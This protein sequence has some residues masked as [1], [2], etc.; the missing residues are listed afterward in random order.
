MLRAITLSLCLIAA[1][2]QFAK[3]DVY[4][5]DINSIPT[6]PD[7]GGEYTAGATGTGGEETI[8][9]YQTPIYVLS[10][11]GL[12]A[13]SEVNLGT[14]VLSSLYVSDQYR[15]DGYEAPLYSLV[16]GV[17]IHLGFYDPCIPGQTCTPP[18]VVDIPLIFPS[19][20]DVQISY[21]D[22][23]ILPPVPEPATWAMLLIGFAGIGFAGWRRAGHATE[24]PQPRYQLRRLI[25]LQSKSSKLVMMRSLRHCSCSPI[26]SHVTRPE[27]L[28]ACSAM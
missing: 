26:S 5:V 11:L 4:N 22:G 27:Q 2:A 16:T 17:Q 1:A 3:A 28:A 21:V 25:A 20:E 7:T 12:P 6:V 23:Y 10:A 15:D 18:A 14:L 9:G 24:T 8:Y 19:S 13:G